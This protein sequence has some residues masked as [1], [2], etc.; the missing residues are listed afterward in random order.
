MDFIDSKRTYYERD[1]KRRGWHGTLNGS[2]VHEIYSNYL[3]ILDGLC[4]THYSNRV[5]YS[6]AHHT[7]SE[8]S[9]TR[10][11]VNS[12]A[13]VVRDDGTYVYTSIIKV[14]DDGSI[15][16]EKISIRK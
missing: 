8:Q 14:W 4:G 12:H 15:S 13:V 11:V 10:R 6:D 5:K 16:R 3:N 1:L 9:V 7:R 2:S